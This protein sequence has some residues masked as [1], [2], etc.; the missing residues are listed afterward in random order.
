MDNKVE[1]IGY[2]GGDL[3]HALSAWT[4]TS[5]DLTDGK[6][7]RIPKLLKYLA[8]NKH[9]TPFEKSTL[10]FLVNADIA[11]HIHVLKHRI[12]VAVNTESARY[13]ELKEDKYYIPTDWS[14]RAKK[15]LE[16][17]VLGSLDCY[18]TEMVLV[19]NELF[20]KYKNFSVVEYVD[21]KINNI[22]RI[23]HDKEIL[24]GFYA[25]GVDVSITPLIDILIALNPEENL[26]EFEKEVKRLCRKRAKESVRYYLPYATQLKF[27]VMFNWRSFAHFQGLRNKPDA[28]FE[29]REIAEEMLELVKNIEGNPFE[30]T[31]NAFNF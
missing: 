11:S 13:R 1:L 31:I 3:E 24:Y 25:D 12:A 28:Q 27:D 22:G 2:Y 17:H 7:N 8:E 6:R 10:H 18:H 15:A 4:S 26:L 21:P 20:E 19:T 23:E 14:D 16:D 29:I 30:H 9:H 5:R